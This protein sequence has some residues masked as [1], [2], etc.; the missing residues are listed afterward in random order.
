MESLRVGGSQ[1]APGFAI[2][3]GVVVFHTT[4]RMSFK[5]TFEHDG[6]GKSYGA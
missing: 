1:A 6:K 5:I 3:E 2:P 4:A